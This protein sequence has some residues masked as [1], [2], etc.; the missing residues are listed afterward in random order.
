LLGGRA[1]ARASELSLSEAEDLALVIY[2]REYGDG[3]LGYRVVEIEDRPWVELAHM[4][5]Y[6]FT[7]VAVE[8]P[9]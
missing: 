7:L 6:D 8:Q 9:A 2:L 3:K 1:E 4:G 5:F